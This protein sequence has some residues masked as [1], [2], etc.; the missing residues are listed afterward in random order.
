MSTGSRC[1]LSSHAIFLSS[2]ADFPQHR[3]D[4]SLPPALYSWIFFSF[5]TFLTLNLDLLRR[6]FNEGGVTCMLD[7]LSDYSC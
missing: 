3:H 4:S 5:L 1:P 7:C 6:F 2:L